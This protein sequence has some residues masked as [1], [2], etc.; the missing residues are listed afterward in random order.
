MPAIYVGLRLETYEALRR[1]AAIERRRPR[2]QAA[3]ILERVLRA[4][5]VPVIKSSSGSAAD[6]PAQESRR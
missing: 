2:D 1:L 3:I 4:T 6:R 5:R